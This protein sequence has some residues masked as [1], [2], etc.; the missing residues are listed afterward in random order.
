M[1]S[2]IRAQSD[3]FSLAM[4]TWKAA[5]EAGQKAVKLTTNLARMEVA[6]N[7]AHSLGVFYS[8]TLRALAKMP[9]DYPYRKYTEEVSRVTL[10][11][12]CGL[13]LSFLILQ[14]INERAALVKAISCPKELE[15]KIGCGQVEEVIVQAENEL[16]LARAILET[17]A[18][19]PLVEEPRPTQWKWPM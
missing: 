15:E 16:V 4:A 13:P 9:A 1:S 11:W 8:K 17:K 19:E 7:P 3:P 10:W 14:I 2:G 5:S 12:R 6:R 18:W